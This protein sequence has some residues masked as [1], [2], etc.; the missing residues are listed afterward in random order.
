MKRNLCLLGLALL[1]LL[2]CSPASRKAAEEGRL[3][4][5][6]DRIYAAMSDEERAAQL[7]G[8]R[9]DEV[10]ENGKLSVEKCREKIPY[11]I[12]HICQYA[13][14]LEMDGEEL[15]DFVRELQT[16]LINETP[17]GI[18]AI[19]HE[20]AITGMAAKGATV[21]PQQLGAACSWNPALVQLKTSQTSE[22]MRSLGATLALS[23][24]VDLIRTAHWSRIEESYGEDAY[25]SSELGVA[26]VRGLQGD[27]LTKGVA[28]CT[29]HFLGYG[30]ASTLS[31]KE[32]Y[33]EVLMP[34]EAAI[35]LAGSKVLMTSYGRFRSEQAVSSDTLIN[36]ILRGYLGYDGLI[37]SD[38]GAVSHSTRGGGPEIFKQR[39]V[40]ALTAGNDIEL[41]SPRCYKYVPE[42]VASGAISREVFE[43]SVKRSLMLKARLGL[44][45]CESFCAEGELELDKPEHRQT[46][47]ELA[48]QSIVMLKNDGTLPLS[49]DKFRKI[50]LVGPN[51]NTF[52]CM[53]GDYTYQSMQAFWQSNEVDPNSPRIVPLYDALK[54][55]AEG[56]FDISYERGCDWSSA[57]EI[58]ITR[59]GDPRTE[60]LNLML[61][62]SVDPT[63][64]QAAIKK[65]S[66]S[67]VI[68]AALGEN[69][70]LC[71]EN[72][73]R[74][75]ILLPGDQ[76]KFL[77]ELIA[78]GKPVVLI[79]FG[80]RPQVLG[81]AADGCAAILQA[82]YP[83]EE[84]GNAVADILTGKVN[85]SAK[86]CVS[87]PA[88]EDEAL[89]CYNDRVATGK[90]QWPFG[91]GLSY[92]SFAYD[93]MEVQSS[94]KTTGKTIKVSCS[95]SNTGDRAGSEIVQLYLS[96]EDGQPLK[97]IQLKA[98]ARVDLQPGEK[99]SVTF[100]LSPE[101]LAYYDCDAA[102]WT[103]SPGEYRFS[104]GASCED[105]R[106]CGSCRLEGAEKHMSL[107]NELLSKVEVR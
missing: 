14:S 49:E 16:W 88:T 76:E 77:R 15:R 55:A 69:P 105:I 87:Y 23:P 60:K 2:S 53:L 72:R 25:L 46:A 104:V 86:L 20:E 59:G 3:S 101:Q 1:C 58:S 89:Y 70:T 90:V 95:V 52:W 84:G 103:V 4:K 64:W 54:T 98:F 37:V 71:G 99:R 45:S 8:I 100:T 93:D 36:H 44:L 74:K 66:E 24:M 41:P 13:C 19:F 91:Y 38:Y 27:D 43:R 11:G 7:Y 61:M 47:Y 22:V 97:P 40:E 62:K 17:S 50:A 39:A 57:E 12:G 56:R 107:R 6:V 80:G 48:C 67:D 21:Y 81:E 78:T 9:P 96:P 31:W 85:P 106:L 63:D 29:K 82:W 10:M 32:L 34:H 94:A 26:F 75:G 73:Q 92:T 30:G 79:M 102:I 83:G 42:L 28:A 65:A 18:P 35:R 33:E 68:V 5:Q 51:A